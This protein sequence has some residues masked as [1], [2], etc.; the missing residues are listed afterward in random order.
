MVFN[1]YS[2]S[3]SLII[4]SE[5][6]NE[7]VD[8]YSKELEEM[9]SEAEIVIKEGTLSTLIVVKPS[10]EALKSSIFESFKEELK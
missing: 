6:V 5:K 3:T 2:L 1:V 8:S 9:D 7:L 10:T 4:E